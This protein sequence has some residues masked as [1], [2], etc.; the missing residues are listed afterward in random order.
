MFTLDVFVTQQRPFLC[1]LDHVVNYPTVLFLALVILIIIT[2]HTI[3]RVDLIR[4]RRLAIG[5]NDPV[6][7]RLC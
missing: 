3:C 7:N 2:V 6:N 4:Y 1:R 5:M